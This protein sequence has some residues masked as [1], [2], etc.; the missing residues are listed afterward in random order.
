MLSS[1]FVGC[2]ERTTHYIRSK[3]RLLH[4]SQFDIH[5]QPN[6]FLAFID[7]AYNAPYTIHTGM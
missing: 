6:P 1:N 2:A 5:N 3:R 4:H 7:G